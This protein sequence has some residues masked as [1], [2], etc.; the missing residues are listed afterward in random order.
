[1]QGRRTVGIGFV[2]VGRLREQCSNAGRVARFDCVE[3]RIGGRRCTGKRRRDHKH[4]D[5]S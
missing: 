3:Q 2:R 4:A 5:R 1:M